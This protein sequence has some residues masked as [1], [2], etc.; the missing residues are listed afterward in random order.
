[1]NRLSAGALVAVVVAIAT[2]VAVSRH[3]ASAPADAAAAATVPASGASAPPAPQ[4]VG[5]AT[6]QVHD[7]PVV[8]ETSGSVVPVD[9]VDVRA[10]TSA[11]V[12]K[13]LLKDGQF[14]RRGDLLFTL[15]DRVDRANLDKARQQALKDRA[16]LA[17]AQRQ[18]ARS[19]DLAAQ[20]FLSPSAI[21][22]A[23]ATVDS[24]QAAVRAD[25]AAVQGAE[26]A[27]SFDTVR[28]PLAGRAGL[29]NV[30]PGALVTPTGTPLVT[31]SRIDPVAVQ[32]TVAEADVGSLLAGLKADSAVRV[33]PGADAAPGNV[34]AAAGAEAASAALATAR[35][36]AVDGRLVFV[37][38]AIDAT[39]GTIKAK[40]EFPNAK[41]ALWPGQFVRVRLTLRTL[42]GAVVIPQA[43]VVQR[44]GDRGVY[45]EG[46]GHTAQWRPVTLVQGVGDG[47]AVQGLAAGERVVVAGKQNVR[48][49]TP[50]RD[51]AAEAAK[52]ASG[53]ASKTGAAS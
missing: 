25:E 38:N 7:V 21:D 17:D 3:P 43:A 37:D 22:T 33:I 24:A 32:F 49:G 39:T 9:T 44:G 20:N 47:V 34:R 45:V 19:R 6:A 48:P 11:T 2:G 30:H 10:Q 1:M 31:I 50:L 15:D 51:A 35:S 41:Q 40:A 4:V 26:A 14:V 53:A 5:L 23:Q 36:D 18:L 46:P 8:I 27:L 12:S 16:T 28:A 52:A 42:A 13:V 29:V